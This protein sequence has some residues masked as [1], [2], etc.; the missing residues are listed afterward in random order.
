MR[1][2]VLIVRLATACVV[3]AA[4]GCAAEIEQREDLLSAA[5]FRVK[6]ANTPDRLQSLQALPPHRFVRESLNGREVWAYADPTVCRCLYVG[7]PDAYQRY[8]Q[9]NVQQRIANENLAAAQL[10]SMNWG[11]GPYGWGPWGPWGF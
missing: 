3:L 10:A 9:L 4:A 6:T 11:Y 2:R 8:Q 5:G 1:T 7:A